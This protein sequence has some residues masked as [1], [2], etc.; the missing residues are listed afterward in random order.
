MK[1]L[2]KTTNSERQNDFV[3]KTAETTTQTT[4]NV[5]DEEH[6]YGDYHADYLV[7]NND[8]RNAGTF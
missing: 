7:N 5:L 3:T 6:A 1:I 4:V 8:V 2:P